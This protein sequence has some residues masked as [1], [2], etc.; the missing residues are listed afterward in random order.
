MKRQL[1]KTT[2]ILV[3]ILSLT[4]PVFASGEWRSGIHIL[5][6]AGLLAQEEYDALNTFAAQISNEYSCGIYIMTV[7]DFTAYGYGYDIF[8]AAW[9][10]YHNNELGFG[11]GRDGMILMLSMA[12]RDYAMF[13]YGQAEYAFNSYGQ[14]Q[15]EGEILDNFGN[16]DWFGGFLDYLETSEQYLS[17]AAQGE[18]VRESPAG[19]AGIFV[20]IAVAISAIVT[21][22]FWGQ[23]RNV[24]FNQEAS[25]Y[26][27]DGGLKLRG[28]T[29]L[30]L[31]RSRSVR[32]IPKQTSSSGSRTGGGGS[33]RSGKF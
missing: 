15:L 8:E 17:L 13:F 11:P 3:L 19:I 25:H 23:M 30:F 9:Q 28:R 18:P 16:N 6:R 10:I 27:T 2:L 33:G 4:L 1:L 32:K 5:D 7:P 24:H 29:D 26:V 21:G 14:E 20:L 22:I 12:D 31:R